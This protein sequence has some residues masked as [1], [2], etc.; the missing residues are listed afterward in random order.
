MKL[1]VSVR[2][3]DGDPV[4]ILDDGDA[5]VVVRAR[6]RG[7]ATEVSAVQVFGNP[8]GADRLAVHAARDVGADYVLRAGAV[9]PATGF[10]PLPGGGPR[11]TWRALTNAGMPPLPSWALS[12][13][14]IELF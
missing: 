14:D 5:A 6:R 4:T 12:L 9:N 11:L 1:E 13:G 10:V 8:A 3:I 2:N 7:E